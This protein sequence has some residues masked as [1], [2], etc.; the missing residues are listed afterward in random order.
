MIEAMKQALEAL[1][2]AF[3]NLRK[4]NDNCFLHDDGGEFDKC[5]CGKDSLV[6]YLTEQ[7]ENLSQAIEQADKQERN[8]CSRCGKRLGDGI[9]TCTP[10][11]VYEQ[12]HTD[13]P[14]RHW[15]RTCPACLAE[16]QEPVKW[17]KVSDELPKL[18]IPV[19]A[20]YEGSSGKLWIVRAKWIPK[21]TEEYYGDDDFFEYD[22]ATDT[23]YIQEGWYECIENWDDYSFVKIN[24]GEV[25]HWME[26]PT[27]PNQVNTASPR[28]P[29]VGMTVDEIVEISESDENTGDIWMALNVQAKLKERNT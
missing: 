5:F 20:C 25:T 24:E 21:N 18:G 29:W 16:K 12:T 15:D 17:K 1:E 11:Q 28:K 2:L 13:H 4:H 7:I 27:A 3:D 26:L 22:E 6:N 23:H 9:H 8:F 10:P 19:L 14:M